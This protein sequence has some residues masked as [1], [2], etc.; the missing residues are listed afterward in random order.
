MSSTHRRR[1]CFSILKHGSLIPPHAP[2]SVRW[3]RYHFDGAKPPRPFGPYDLA[4][5]S[6]SPVLSD[7][8]CQTLISAVVAD[9][10]GWMHDSNDRYGTAATMLPARYAIVDVVSSRPLVSSR[11]VYAML[12]DRVATWELSLH[13]LFRETASFADAFTHLRLKRAAIVRYDAALGETE[14]GYHKDGP[15]IT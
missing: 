6:L 3:C 13:I 10:H 5:I 7:A 12:K 2:G 4:R 15:L 1:R 11:S 14:L 9:K 8:E